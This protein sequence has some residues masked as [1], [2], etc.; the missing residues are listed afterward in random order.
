M[1]PSNSQIPA[2]FSSVF[3]VGS[4]KQIFLVKKSS[5]WG[6]L[7][8]GVIFAGLAGIGFIAGAFI[9]YQ[10][11]NQFGPATT[12]QQIQNIL[13][14]TVCVT[15]ILF[16]IGIAGLW[17]AFNNWQKAVVTYQDGLGYSDNKGVRTLRW[18]QVAGMTSAVTKHYRNGIYTGTTHLYT[19][20][21]RD[22]KKLVLNDVFPKVEDL[23]NI[24]RQGTFPHLYKAA[25][26]NYNA[27]KT[28]QFGPVTIGKMDGI[29]V[30]KKSYKWEEVEQVS[31]H[32]GFLK[33]AKKGGGWFSGA[34]AAIAAIPNYEVLISIINQVVGVKAG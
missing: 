6:S 3:G 31:L 23:A 19:L 24:I 20:W 16:L 18:D 33:V 27:G 12:Q 17:S 7:I 30:Q 29:T 10:N 15:G 8:A 9:T 34:N 25:A 2:Q 22:G 4:P 5:K 32:Q 26:D 11:I 1:T 14:P 28:V 21:D 13:F